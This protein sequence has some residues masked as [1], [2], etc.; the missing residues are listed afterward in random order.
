MPS[1][2][3]LTLGA[4][5]QIEQALNGES[6]KGRREPRVAFVGRSNV[7]KSSLINALLGR[8]L[9][10]VSKEPGKTRCIHFYSWEQT[11]KI[12][13]DLPG[14]GYAKVSQTERDRWAGFIEAYLKSDQA[15]SRVLILLDSRHGP[16]KVDEDA[17]S[18]FHDSLSFRHVPITFVM[19]KSDSLKTQSQR[20][21]RKR[22]A[23]KALQ[24]LGVLEKGEEPIWVSTTTDLGLRE[25]QKT[26]E[27]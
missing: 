12:V 21:L 5:D 20:V 6:L 23:A 22:E 25:L 1:E 10:Q 4:V 26:I 15:L 16:T 9:A 19:T 2:H 17:I 11:G 8:R 13:A 3:L 14:Y 24:K 27:S 18:Y 7:G